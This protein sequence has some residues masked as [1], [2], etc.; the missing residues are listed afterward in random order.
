MKRLR[1]Y[2]AILCINSLSACA[3]TQELKSQVT[4][5]TETTRP[6]ETEQVLPAPSIL[7]QGTAKELFLKG[8]NALEHGEEQNARLLLQQ[9][10]V[11]EPNHKY[12]A[13]LL[14]QINADPV[15]MLGKDNFTYKVQPGDTLSKIA[16]RFLGD[17][18]KFYILGRYNDMMSANLNAGRSIKIP[19]KKPLPSEQEPLSSPEASSEELAEAA[20]LYKNNR[21]AEAI[22][23]LEEFRS[24]EGADARLDDLLLTIYENYANKLS[25]SGQLEEAT[26]LLSRALKTYPTSERLKKQFDQVEMSHSAEQT[27]K[28]GN[29]LLN[30]E[31]P[32]KAYAKYTLTLKLNPE[33]RGAK[34]ALQKIKS[35]VVETYYAQSIR[36]RRRQEFTD[37]LLSL[38]KL[39]EIDP[40]HKL[41][42]ENRREI[43]ALLE[44]EQSSRRRQ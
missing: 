27:Y 19:G 37:A 14:I 31:E 5:S 22:N 2:T 39:L 16:E 43:K 4:K 11:L 25:H 23:I 12:A 1:V 21:F 7:P 6:T 3:L 10:L 34:A 44:R 41:A 32:A 36:A 40:N 8:I 15:S 20:W 42:R 9:V 30:D 38:D 29:R 18:Y 24:K 26:T 35:Q 13:G 33:H 28:E 17:R